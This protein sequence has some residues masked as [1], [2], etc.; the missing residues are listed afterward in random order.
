MPSA[1]RSRAGRKAEPRPA[2]GALTRAPRPPAW[3]TPEARAEWKRIAADV[4]AS[5]AFAPVH[6]PLLENYAVHLGRVR[7]LEKAIQATMAA[8][9]D[10]SRLVRL[11][12]AA[13]KTAIRYGA[14]LYASPAAGSRLIASS[15]E[16]DD[17]LDDLGLAA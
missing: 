4:I 16:E 7:E 12:D 6:L 14:E 8:G 10:I 1:S 15:V 11:Q 5:G 13:S 9:G 3:L 2:K 17:D